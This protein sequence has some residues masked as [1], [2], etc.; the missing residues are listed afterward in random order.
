MRA[1]DDTE[2]LIK[3]RGM[4]A[5]VG[6][7][8][9][10]SASSD[11]LVFFVKIHLFQDPLGRHKGDRNLWRTISLQYW[12]RLLNLSSYPLKRDWPC[13]LQVKVCACAFQLS[14]LGSCWI[15]MWTN[16]RLQ[17]WELRQ[18]S[19]LSW[20]PRIIKEASQN[21]LTIGQQAI[22]KAD[23]RLAQQHRPANPHTHMQKEAKGYCSK[24]LRFSEVC[25]TAKLSEE[26]WP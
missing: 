8:Y 20:G 14:L 10:Y 25:Y 9:N 19:L 4:I 1:K 6:T 16:E 18:P 23:F 15:A 12:P 3:A 5:A 2:L 22:D 24:P 26:T 21:Q 11:R 17:R 13:D 7:F